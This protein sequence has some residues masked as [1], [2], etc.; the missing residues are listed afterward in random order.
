MFRSNDRVYRSSNPTLVGVV[1]MSEGD[2]LFI[3]WDDGSEEWCLASSLRSATTGRRA[4][5]S[6]IE[7]PEI[8]DLEF[9]TR[10]DRDAGA[11]YM[12]REA[13]YRGDEAAF[14]AIESSEDIFALW[15]GMGDMSQEHIVVGILDASHHL[16]AWKAV[17]KGQLETVEA[18]LRQILGDALLVGRARGIVMLHNHP[19]GDPEPSEDDYNLTQSV[20]QLGN[21]L[22]LG[23]YDHVVVGRPAHGRS[24]YY[25][26]RDEGKLNGEWTKAWED[27]EDPYD[28]GDLPALSEAGPLVDASPINDLR[29]DV[30][31][32]PS[33]DGMVLIRDDRYRGDD[34]SK[35]SVA[36][37]LEVVS[38]FE[39][40]GDEDVLVVLLFDVRQSLIGWSATPLAGQSI[41]SFLRRIATEILMTNAS[42]VALIQNERRKN[43]DAVRLAQEVMK[44]TA[45]MDVTFLDSVIVGPDVEVSMLEEDLVPGLG[46]PPRP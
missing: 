18:S 2:E 21:E 26:F 39:S 24:S 8:A 10:L 29:Y 7:A 20:E 4:N 30:E 44:M 36:T 12:V 5:P 14:P 22:G 46:V 15:S 31:R 42:C 25:S 32:D 28:R 3:E 37:A 11:I 13:T 6:P 16:V 27:R 35:P 34:Q 41:Q 17:H 19:S 1:C 23:L 40:L 38:L 43:E 45:L 9:V 33:G